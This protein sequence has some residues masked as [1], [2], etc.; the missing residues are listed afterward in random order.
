MEGVNEGDSPEGRYVAATDPEFSEETR[1]IGANLAAGFDKGSLLPAMVAWTKVFVARYPSVKGS[2]GLLWQATKE[3]T[4]DSF[5]AT[6]YGMPRGKAVVHVCT[7]VI[8]R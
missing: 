1:R 6:L 4:F 5:V 3:F 7:S 2:D 8:L